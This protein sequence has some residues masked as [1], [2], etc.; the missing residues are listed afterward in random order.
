MYKCDFSKYKTI[1]DCKKTPPIDVKNYAN[2]CGLD[3]KKFSSKVKQCDEIFRIK[4]EQISNQNQEPKQEPK[5]KPLCDL[6]RYR[7]IT[8]CKKTP[9]VELKNYA[10]E[11][12]LDLKTFS[13]KV[14]QCDEIFRMKDMKKTSKTS[15]KRKSSKKASKKSSRKS[16]RKSSKKASKKVSKKVVDDFYDYD[17]FILQKPDNKTVITTSKKLS[18]L[19]Y[20]MNNDAQNFKQYF[21]DNPND[22]L[23]YSDKGEPLFLEAITHGKQKIIDAMV[24]MEISN[25]EKGKG[26]CY[27]LYSNRYL[28]LL[29][30]LST[31]TKQVDFYAENWSFDKQYVD[32]GFSIYPLNI[33]VN[34]SCFFDRRG[35]DQ[36]ACDFPKIRWQSGDPRKRLRNI[37]GTVELFIQTNKLYNLDLVK[38][39]I[40][41]VLPFV[42]SLKVVNNTIQFDADNFLKNNPLFRKELS[43]QYDINQTIR[44]VK[45]YIDY[46]LNTVNPNE[47][48]D[49]QKLLTVYKNNAFPEYTKDHS[50]K[51]EIDSNILYSMVSRLKNSPNTNS[52]GYN[53][54]L[55]LLLFLGGL[56]NIESVL[57]DVYTILRIFKNI[58][59]KPYYVYCYFGDIHVEHLLHYFTYIMKSYKIVIAK[60]SQCQN[61][62]C[63]CISFN[64]KE[65][66]ENKTEIRKLS[67]PVSFYKLKAIDKNMRPQYIT[68]F[69]DYHGS[70]KGQCKEC[71]FDYLKLYKQANKK[72]FK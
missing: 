51:V 60:V 37:M 7:T 11:C 57:L 63:R 34:N 48:N 53:F 52:I 26:T 64:P 16:S 58:P 5:F 59:E 18:L 28:T 56:I 43:K 44:M 1:T 55:L 70:D 45:E 33:I 8:D 67:G 32:K 2:E 54:C 72:L 40:K 3:L 50:M 42:E 47:L 36:Y 12:G 66:V 19:E 65:Y 62:M 24:E 6:D 10:N 39:D 15:K 23:F 22:S 69:G 20:L 30:S 4:K 9:S 49:I 17:K 13:T 14:K 27:Q 38:E 71:N 25:R 29:E 31:P 41:S 35:R 68:L 61:K 46:C 21:N